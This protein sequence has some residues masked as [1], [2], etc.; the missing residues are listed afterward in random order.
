MHSFYQDQRRGRQKKLSITSTHHLKGVMTDAYKKVSPFFKKLKVT[1]P[2]LNSSQC[3]QM[4]IDEIMALLG[5][6][7]DREKLNLIEHSP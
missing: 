3:W 1:A 6:Y 4:I 2:Q 7:L 5:I